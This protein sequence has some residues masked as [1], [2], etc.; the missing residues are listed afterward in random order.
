MKRLGIVSH[1]RM[2]ISEEWLFCRQLQKQR[3]GLMV[4]F[5]WF[6][7]YIWLW[8]KEGIAMF[9]ICVNITTDMVYN[10]LLPFGIN[11]DHYR[12]AW[13]YGSNMI[14]LVIKIVE[15]DVSLKGKIIWASAIIFLPFLLYH[16]RQ[17]YIWGE[18]GFSEPGSQNEVCF[19]IKPCRNMIV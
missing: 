14:A 17:H 13:S 1:P 9:K 15:L 8:K 19:G 5:C 18:G 2:A 7:N 12:A 4:G 11:Q 16:K 6:N 10:S 3:P